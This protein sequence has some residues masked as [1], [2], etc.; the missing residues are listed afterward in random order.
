MEKENEFFDFNSPLVNRDLKAINNFA[1]WLYEKF[2][3]D[4]TYYI[5]WYE[6]EMKENC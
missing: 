2:E 5:E 1:N 3:I 4:L 6:D